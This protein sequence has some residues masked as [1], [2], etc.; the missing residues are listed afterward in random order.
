ML[1]NTS[2]GCP[3]PTLKVGER[4]CGF[5]VLRIEHIPDIRVT[6]YEIEHE[7]TDAKVLHLHCD[8]GENLY[9]I[10]F[11]TPPSDS[12][13]IAHILEHSVLAGSEKY[14]LKDV[15]NE[16]AK[17]TLQ[18][19]INAFT[20][21]DKT[22]YP[23]ASQV[24]SDFF[25]LARVYTD[26]VFNPRLLK[27]TFHQE[28]HHLEFENPEDIHSDLTISGI[29]YN[30]MKGVYSSPDSLMY[31]AI[32]EGLYP[33]T[34]YVF[35]SGGDPDVIPSLTYEQ[36]KEF[37]RAFYSPTNARFFLYGNIPSK[38]YLA[39]LEKMLSRFDRVRVNSSINSQSRWKKPSKSHGY[40]PIGQQE[41]LKRKTA[42]NVAW[43]MAENTD[44]ETVLLL[45][46]VSEALVGSAA[47]PLR[48]GLI[49]SG[50][51][52]DLSP[53]T[54]LEMDLKQLAFAVGL[55]GSDPDKAERIERLI[56]E[57]LKKVAESGFDPELIEGAL[58]QV[59]FHGKEIVRSAMPYAII[60]MG[61]V[62]HTWLYDGDPLV[63]LNFSAIIETI[64]KKWAHNAR[65]F[66]E[67]VQKWFLDNSHRLLSIMEPSRTH[68]EEQDSAFRKK[69]I[70][71]KNSFSRK[72]LENIRKEA[73]SLRRKQIEPDTPEAIATLPKL[74]LADIPR[75]IE[76][77]PTV[78]TRIADIPALEHE[79]FANG[80]AY[81]DLA[82]DV[83]DIPEDLQPYLPLLGKLTTGMG[84]AGRGYEE[85]AKRMALKTGGL[86]Y[87]LVTGMT[88]NGK[89]NWQKMI[90]SVKALHRNIGE[91]VKIVADILADGD[92]SDESRMRDLIAESKN[93]LH[94]AIVPSGHTF[95]RRTAA[96]ALSVPA[97][98]DEQWGG[99]TQLRL[100]NRISGEFKDQARKLRERF[101]LL[102]N[103]L[104]RRQRLIL[105]LTSDTKGLSL[106]A[107]AT[108]ELI[109]R[110]D[111]GGN[112]GPVSI[113]ALR[114]VHAGVSIPA[115]VC[116]VAKVIPAPMYSEPLSA[117]LLVLARELSSGYL[118]KRI[119]VQGGA[120]GG[121]SLY[122]SMNGNFSF[123][124]YRDPN[125]VET[126]K[127][128]DNAVD[129]VSQNKIAT[130]ALEKAI[131]GTIGSLDKP[132]DPR[133][134]GY[135]AMIRDL[136]GLTDEDRQKFRNYVLESSPES[137]MEA[138]NHYL[139]QGLKSQAI[140]VYA[141]AERLKL[142]NNVLE[143]KLDIEPLV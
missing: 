44:Y 62:Y 58:H 129:F 21:P 111:R 128:Y 143:P 30:E 121:M 60:L 55:R 42:I 98:R 122:D 103:M 105:N 131:I 51:G 126:L 38:D 97:Y 2:T 119:R 87:S 101:V 140:A 120:Y 4:L 81:L 79:I 35:D 115:Q 133:S 8:D 127:T 92:L 82:F 45:Q 139:K 23:V 106:L 66:Q 96:A 118:Y 78:K 80:I 28:G 130:E 123:L 40:Y 75:M 117:S 73:A 125:L 114:P 85:M 107:E 100:L 65:L 53:V 17:G 102:R 24:R 29:V 90:F 49:D 12:T 61:R 110:L 13:G 59:E 19:F 47:G 64:R 77:I 69:M 52:E 50:L 124:S 67:I 1:M 72:E 109:N 20:Y 136:A 10:G 104:F 99:R 16:L 33:Q 95:A 43:M 18:T 74:K 112:P 88:I 9:A 141:A 83:S 6:A 134:K 41:D 63:G 31:K 46:I 14:P 135:I 34:T 36:L 70:D 108:N 86:G 48:K 132:M 25:N 22:I 91:A 26:L 93:A 56:I 7:K 32:Q 76:I 68:A 142:A 138:A 57:I 71:L 116:Y 37:H 3:P 94:S 84:A 137:L 113:P 15:F 27:D 5:Y 39:F 89:G 11:R 54:G